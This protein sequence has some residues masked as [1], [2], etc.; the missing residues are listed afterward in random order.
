MALP[1]NKLETP[2]SKDAYA[3]IGWNWL[4]GAGEEDFLKISSMYFSNFGIMSPWKRVGP[5]F[6][7]TWIPIIKGCLCQNWLQL[8]QW[9]WRRGFFKNFINVFSLFRNYL[10]LEK[11]GDLHLNKLESPYKRM[12]L[13]KFGWNW[14]SGFEEAFFLISSIYF[15]FFVIISLW[16]RAGP[17]IWTNMNP[18]H[19]RRFCAK[20]VWN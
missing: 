14:L 5:S 6:E 1:L 17:F 12:I 8:A 11:G 10:P 13:A 4:S 3:K 7:Q 19:P 18:L 2:S 9:F 20:F 16:K 15:H